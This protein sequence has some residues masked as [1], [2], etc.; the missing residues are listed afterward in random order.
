MG[1]TIGIDLGTTNSCMAILEGGEPTVIENAEGA[2]TTPS[3]VAFTDGGERLVG[4][5]AKRQAVTNP[6]NTVFSIK[7]FMGRKEAE[8]KEEEKIVPFEVVAGPNGDARVKAGGKEYAPPEISAMILQKLKADAEAYLGDSVD[9][10]VITVPA[11][12]NDDQRQATKDAGKVAGLDV[13]RII[14]EPTAAALAYGLEKEETDQTILVFDLGGGTFDVS[15]LEIG[16]GVFE[17]KATAGDNHLG[18]DN[19]DKAVVDWLV[20]EFKKAEGVDLSQDK[21]AL[22]RLYQEAEKAKTEL[23]SAQETQINLPFITAIDSV[24]KH[25][26]QR[27][28]RSKLNELTA[29][30]LDRVVGPTKQALTDAGMEGGSGIDHVV[31]VGGMTRMPAVQEKVKELTGK[32]PHRGVNPDEVVAVGAAI[33]AGVL[34]GDVKDVL[35]LDV[36]PLTLGIETKGGV[37]TKLI[38]RN[39]TIPTRKSEIFSTAEDNQPSVEVHVLQGEREMAAYNKSLGKFQLT[40]IPPAPR[41]IPQVEVTFDID[42][43][44]ILN[45]GAKDLGTGKEQKIEIKAG[46]GLADAEVERMVADAEAHA[47]DDRRQRELVEARN[48]AENAAYQAERQVKEMEDTLDSSSKEEIEAAIK[49]VRDNLESDDVALLNSKTEALQVAFHKVSEQMY[50]AAQQQASAGNGTT[51]DADASSTNGSADE[52]EVVDAEVV[53]GDEKG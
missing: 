23:S 29:D 1:K 32:D 11:Y 10:A 35:L 25:L 40:G 48:A 42:A 17:V 51:A 46:S 26:N 36:T 41:G 34:A 33:Q 22:Q 38:E 52:E 20:S 9:A 43:N 47:E 3:V 31:L 49:D 39:T 37:M 53:E 19:F 16:E 5:P 24:P 28:T 7:R 45:V 14:N 30:L 27:L 6:E 2:R 13:K 18:G 12:F 8:V 44:G 21:M 4:A 15:V 50:A